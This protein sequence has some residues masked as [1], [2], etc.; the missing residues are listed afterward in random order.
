MKARQPHEHRKLLKSASIITLITLLSRIFGYIRDQRTAYLLGTGMAADAFTT[1]YRIPNLLRRLVGE[2]A[3]SAAFIPTFSKYL[4]ED[5]KEEAWRFANAL[6]SFVSVSLA[7]VTVLGILLSPYIVTLIAYGFT[8]TPGKVELTTVLNRIMFPYIFF[9]S[10]SALAMGVL[11]SFHRFAAPA[12][13]SVLLNIC[14]IASSFVATR[15]GA[16][17]HVLAVGVVIGGVVQAAIQ[18]PQLVSSGWRFRFLWD[19]AN[20]GLRRV[21]RLMA[22][23]VFGVGIVQINVLVDTQF[24]STLEQGSVMAL[25]LSDRVMELVLGGYAVALSTAVLPLMSRQAAEMRID[26]MKSTLNFAL[27]LILFITVPSTAGLIILR[28]PIIEVLFEHGDFG[29]RSTMLTAW[30]LLFFAIGLSAFSAMKV[31]VPA[32][33][34]LHDTSTPVKVAFGA[35]FFNVAMNF[36]LI[37]PLQSGGPALATTLAAF[38]NVFTLLAIFR[39]RHGRLGLRKVAVSLARF[40]LG[41]AALAWTAEAII[42]LPGWYDGGLGQRVLALTSA[43]A[44]AAAVYFALMIVLQSREIVEIRGMFGRRKPAAGFPPA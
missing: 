21:A 5:R 11:N 33:Y 35:L 26:E 7:A 36:A 43:I 4:A 34:S 12:F 23:I 15:F 44:G 30:P 3:V 28:E 14:I 2:G 9:V 39:R 19:L 37:G 27:R 25:Y 20:P 16:P 17:A 42:G 8:G 32:F 1:A 10:L 29:S 6:L 22:P 13:A 31:V 41:A 40:L 24:A 18:I 38:F